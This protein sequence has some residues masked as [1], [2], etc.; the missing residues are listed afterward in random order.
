MRRQDDKHDQPEAA[1]SSWTVVP[2]IERAHVTGGNRFRAPK[3]FGV[4][5]VP[6][7]LVAKLRR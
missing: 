1:C 6:A 3:P 4:E 2:Y 7:Q 5:I